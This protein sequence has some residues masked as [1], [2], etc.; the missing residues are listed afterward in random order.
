MAKAVTPK[1][2]TADAQKDM[3]DAFDEAN[4]ANQEYD[5][6]EIYGDYSQGSSGPIVIEEQES[7]VVDSTVTADNS[8]E[9]TSTATP[10]DSQAPASNASESESTAVPAT[11]APKTTAEIYADIL[12]QDIQ[13]DPFFYN[14]GG[15]GETTLEHTLGYVVKDINVS[16][17]PLTDQGIFAL[18]HNSVALQLQANIRS[19]HERSNGTVKDAAEAQIEESLDN[20]VRK[21]ASRDGSP[22]QYIDQPAFTPNL[23]D[24]ELS[25]LKQSLLTTPPALRQ[26]VYQQLEMVADNPDFTFNDTVKLIQSDLKRAGN[27]VEVVSGT[28]VNNRA[29]NDKFDDTLY[30]LTRQ[31]NF[32]VI[33]TDIP[34]LVADYNTNEAQRNPSVYVDPRTGLSNTNTNQAPADQQ[35]PAD[36][37]DDINQR[38]NLA[39]SPADQAESDRRAANDAM[40][41]PDPNANTGPTHFTQD[42][43]GQTTGASTIQPIIEVPIQERMQ[44]ESEADKTD[45]IF[46]LHDRLEFLETLR[47]VAGIDNKN[48]V[49]NNMTSGDAYDKIKLIDDAIVGMPTNDTNALTP[50]D[51]ATALRFLGGLADELSSS[52]ASTLDSALASENV[53]K[54]RDFEQPAYQDAIS[55]FSAAAGDKLDGVLASMHT[56]YAKADGAYPYLIDATN[57][58]ALSATF[59]KKSLDDIKPANKET[60][61]ALRAYTEVSFAHDNYE[62]LSDKYR[63]GVTKDQLSKQLDKMNDIGMRGAVNASNRSLDKNPAASHL[64]TLDNNPVS[65]GAAFS[66]AAD[67]INNHVNTSSDLAGSFK[68]HTDDPAALKRLAAETSEFINYQVAN[69]TYLPANLTAPV[70]VGAIARAANSLNTGLDLSEMAKQDKAI[71]KFGLDQNSWNDISESKALGDLKVSNPDKFDDIQKSLAFAIKNYDQHGNFS[72]KQDIA[73][74]TAN[75]PN[76]FPSQSEMRHAYQE[77][78]RLNQYGVVESEIPTLKHINP[79]ADGGNNDLKFTDRDAQVI[80]NKVERLSENPNLT[81]IDIQKAADL[82]QSVESQGFVAKA[83]FFVREQPKITGLSDHQARV[84]QAAYLDDIQDNSTPT[85]NNLATSLGSGSNIQSES[86]ADTPY[87]QAISEIARVATSVMNNEINP[88]HAG[89]AISNALADNI[90]P[91]PIEVL[92]TQQA[93]LLSVDNTATSTA[94][95]ASTVIP[96]TSTFN[97]ADLGPCDD[98]NLEE[99]DENGNPIQRTQGD[100]NRNRNQ[101]QNQNQNQN[102]S[103]QATSNNNSGG[104]QTITG[105]AALVYGLGNAIGAT[106]SLLANAFPVTRGVIAGAT[107]PRAAN[108]GG[109]VDPASSALNTKLSS[110]NTRNFEDATKSA[111]KFEMSKN[112]LEMHKTDNNLSPSAVLRAKKDMKD[113]FNQYTNTVGNLADSLKLSAPGM[114]NQLRESS[115]ENLSTLHKNMKA[116]VEDAKAKNL[117]K[118]NGVQDRLLDN[119][120]NSIGESLSA[121]RNNLAVSTSHVFGAI[122]SMFGRG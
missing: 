109:S 88:I 18:L 2:N 79:T 113:S 49:H 48:Y 63:N 47:V 68:S 36:S 92:D 7:V 43:Y 53:V 65:N 111:V 102:R 75:F 84:L 98:D 4:A 110:H 62:K 71:K 11:D 57:T 17:K 116:S 94:P 45:R 78:T 40:N 33:G 19:L 66:T 5:P 28:S 20:L 55:N 67:F 23:G 90:N 1:A 59:N 64:F 104:N 8:A 31:H 25:F 76:G 61:K 99:C 16:P 87:N 101:N 58:P 52:P 10:A 107:A 77:M 37:Q 24:T 32:D 86:G 103:Q 38:A 83:D 93:P 69:S 13:D 42:A 6:A 29:F 119:A 41:N 44:Q 51:K 26:S 82:R 108:T 91:A 95:A 27:D 74:N 50:S 121:L 72:D 70:P 12:T 106:A 81:D 85:A 73:P 56:V 97:P 30:A 9:N 100:R 14:E 3:Q 35:N 46:R 54:N 39:Q 96:N 21:F 122:K 114:T 34:R 112:A 60:P 15:I 22:I 105:G 80:F 115:S 89:A 120:N 118:P 117:F